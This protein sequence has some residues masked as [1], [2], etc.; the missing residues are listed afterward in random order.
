MGL[1]ACDIA[2][3][4]PSGAALAADGFQ[5]ASLYVGQ[6]NTG[7]N[8]NATVVAD[9][10]AH[11]VAVITNF[12]YGAQQ[13]L[14]GAT[15]GHTDAVLGLSQA[16]GCGMPGGRPIYFSADWAAT[17][18]Q[19]TSFVIPYLV[20]ARAVLGA[21]NVGVYGSYTTVSTVHAYWAVHF[22]GEK[23]WLWQTAAWS[24]NSLGDLQVFS[25]ID[26]FQD[27]ATTIVG[28]VT[29]DDDLPE[30]TDVGQWPAPPAPAPP[31]ITDGEDEPMH[32]DLSDGKAHVLTPPSAVK[33]GTSALLLSA[34]FGDATVRVAQ[35]GFT[36]HTWVNVEEVSVTAAGGAIPVS[37][38]AD[39]NK[40]SLQVV[41]DTAGGGAVGADIF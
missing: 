36:E 20:A 7:K 35:Y 22:P 26:L 25:P 38:V 4:K 21:A 24:K 28:G 17:P 29:V 18:D 14:G 13:M 40:I 3:N 37:L 12:E 9:Y 19:V 23:I 15:Q 34:D 27:G 39:I 30:T 5:V 41:S 10:H 6:D 11:G 8:M 2:W 31:P 33:G 1:K 16:R 32:I